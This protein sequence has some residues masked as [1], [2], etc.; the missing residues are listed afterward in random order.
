[1]PKEWD[2]A[3]LRACLYRDWNGAY[4][5]LKGAD[6]N[7]TW[8]DNSPH[9][10]KSALWLAIYHQKWGLAYSLIKKGADVNASCAANNQ[11]VLWLAAFNKRWI[12]VKALIKKG[13]NINATCTAGSHKGISVVILAACDRQWELV[14]SLT[15][16][17]AD[18]GATCVGDSLL[19]GV[20]VLWL[21]MYHAQWSLAQTLIKKGANVNATCRYGY[22]KFTSL[23][24]L[25]AHHNQWHLVLQLLTLGANP[26]SL[27]PSTIFYL[28][29][30][31]SNKYSAQAYNMFARNI[32]GPIGSL[33]GSI[34]GLL[35]AKIAEHVQLQKSQ[36]AIDFISE[37]F[38]QSIETKHK[39]TCPEYLKQ[40]VA[41]TD[42]LRTCYGLDSGFY[43]IILVKTIDG[44]LRNADRSLKDRMTGPFYD[45][46]EKLME[47]F[48]NT[49]PYVS[50]KENFKNFAET[51]RNPSW[52][53]RD[54]K[55]F[56][57]NMKTT[58]EE[59][60]VL[61]SLPN[62][63]H[64]RSFVLANLNRQLSVCGPGIFNSILQLRYDLESNDIIQKLAEYRRELVLQA[65]AAYMI[66]HK[67]REG[68]STHVEAAF[69]MRAQLQG[70]APASGAEQLAYGD[71]FEDI[72]I[73]SMA[74]V[75]KELVKLFQKEYT[76]GIILQSVKQS[77]IKSIN[78]IRDNP[79]SEWISFEEYTKIF[80]Q[81]LLSTRQHGLLAAN[82]E[83]YLELIEF[84]EGYTKCRICID[85]FDFCLLQTLARL[86]IADPMHRLIRSNGK[87][88]TYAVVDGHLY[89]SDDDVTN[90]ELLKIALNTQTAENNLLV[91]FAMALI[92]ALMQNAIPVEQF[93]KYAIDLQNTKC[94]KKTHTTINDF[95]TIFVPTSQ[96]RLALV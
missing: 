51:I 12:L 44:E 50:I 80:E 89:K 94:V 38:F 59:I 79:V 19:K 82:G 14:K 46:V 49:S 67:A 86:N 74:E 95:L 75:D 76:L 47:Q 90:L 72:E 4:R 57:T 55:E 96:S 31:A 3:L 11:S 87:T 28:L 40:A 53:D 37:R 13:A 84:D 10:G 35:I 8:A 77:F 69:L 33:R 88:I 24:W 81:L 22:N 91:I 61:I 6:V 45:Q 66:N 42:I 9:K 23:L 25:A 29:Q 5:L 73:R 36:A 63:Q 2:D 15:E 26:I 68:N 93:M 39:V 56:Y 70:F 78:D 16:L 32:L 21:A 85:K 48:A 27:D 34:K 83:F 1:M 20:T 54:N 43:G 64:K 65:A 58:L 30:I 17:G 41:D 18:V 60:F 62:L 52:F 7:A 71:I 92:E